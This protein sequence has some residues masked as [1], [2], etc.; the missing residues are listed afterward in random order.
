MKKILIL[1]PIL[2]IAIVVYLAAD[3]TNQPTSLS[4]EELKNLSFTFI[5]HYND[6]NFDELVNAFHYPEK[7][8]PQE[9]S[10]D[11]EELHRLLD[12]T[13]HYWGPITNHTITT[14]P[15]SQMKLAMASA[16]DFYWHTIHS[17]DSVY[18]QTNFK[19]FPNAVLEFLYH[20]PSGK[21][22]LGKFS[23]M[24]PVDHTLDSLSREVAVE[25][26]VNSLNI[27]LNRGKNWKTQR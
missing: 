22:E 10:K 3:N 20:N 26:V 12:N 4:A 14:K 23:L 16:N 15:I 2:I 25:S 13:Y 18:V 7:F 6:Q 21:A 9:L 5:Q 19:N 11:K 27:I 1:L 17:F 24:G 8:T